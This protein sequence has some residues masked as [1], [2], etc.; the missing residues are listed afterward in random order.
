[1]NIHSVPGNPGWGKGAGS[2]SAALLREGDCQRFPQ[3]ADRG[4]VHALGGV[5]C[6]LAGLCYAELATTYP[7]QGGDLVY[8]SRAYG[9]GAGFLFGWSQMAIIRPGD[10][11]LMA[12]VFSRYAATL[13][14]PFPGARN[15]SPA[16]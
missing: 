11:A 1:M 8:L 9:P 3:T 2:P 4:H 15:G 13:L 10:I 12:F 7:K 5:L 14:P 16:R 6:A